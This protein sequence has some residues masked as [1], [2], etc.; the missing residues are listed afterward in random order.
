MPGGFLDEFL[1][2]FACLRPGLF[3]RILSA[4]INLGGVVEIPGTGAE[5][6]NKGKSGSHKT[7]GKAR[8][9]AALDWNELRCARNEAAL[10]A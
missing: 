4:E 5:H 6:Q 2:I 8:D 7:V 1:F 10:V 3:Q 9:H